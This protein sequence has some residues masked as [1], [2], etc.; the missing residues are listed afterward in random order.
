MSKVT[1]LFKRKI[2][3]AKRKGKDPIVLIPKNMKNKVLLQM[4]GRG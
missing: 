4:C 2:E 3:Q 1:C